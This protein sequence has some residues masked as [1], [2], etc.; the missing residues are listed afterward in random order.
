MVTVTYG[1]RMRVVRLR[2][3]QSFTGRWRKLLHE[4]SKFGVIGAVNTVVNYAV[5]NLLVL[6]VFVNGQ[7]KANVAATI[8]A[9][10]SSYFM[11]RHWTYRD[12]PKSTL[13]REYALF[14]L[15]NLGGLM[16]ELGVLALAK[17]G[18]GITT[19]VALNAAK[20]FAMI[21]GMVFRF[22][23]YRTIVFR[24]APATATAPASASGP[25]VAPQPVSA[26]PVAPPSAAARPAVP[27]PVAASTSHSAHE[28]APHCAQEP[29]PKPVAA[30][31]AQLIG[32]LE[33]ELDPPLDAAL[34]AELDSA[35]FSANRTTQS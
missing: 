26:R 4:L 17:Y 5:F 24:E 10:T 25:P 8:V 23:T 20:A 28:P 6:T 22:F 2:L 13:H 27:P 34:Q 19:L 35:E 21:L 30:E 1:D 33:V 31:F 11:N 16:I 9:T 29:G 32:P 14:F 7:L 3:P 15:F 12:R 18:L